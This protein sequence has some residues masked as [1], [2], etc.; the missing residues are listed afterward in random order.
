MI[1]GTKEKKKLRV[2]SK[3]YVWYMYVMTRV[4]IIEDYSSSALIMLN[5]NINDNL[6]ITLSVLLINNLYSI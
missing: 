2:L 5:N 1:E 3:R 6:I 4:N